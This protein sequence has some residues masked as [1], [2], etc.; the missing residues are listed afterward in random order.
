MSARPNLWHPED[1]S[2]R[3]NPGHYP[4][5][6]EDLCDFYYRVGQQSKE[7]D[8]ARNRVWRLRGWDFDIAA[9]RVVRGAAEQ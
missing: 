9:F 4:G 6:P 2:W 8:L 1:T 5:N 3:K 7:P